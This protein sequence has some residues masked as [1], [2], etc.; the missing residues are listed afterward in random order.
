MPHQIAIL[1]LFLLIATGSAQAAEP[2]VNEAMT[3]ALLCRGNPI[4]AVRKIAA[5]E[6]H[7]FDR[8]FAGTSYGED[9]DAKDI[10]VLKSPLVI[11]GAKASAVIVDLASSYSDFNGIVFA[12]F[13]GD[14]RRVVD[15]LGLKAVAADARAPVGKFEKSLGVDLDGKPDDFC[16]MTIGLTPL[17]KQ[18]EFLLGCGWCNG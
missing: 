18:G 2:D 12:V 7:A 1:F 15:Q 16:P 3:D 5:L 8:G 4:D 10:V 11:A 9:M 17:E 6:N 14:Y 13:H